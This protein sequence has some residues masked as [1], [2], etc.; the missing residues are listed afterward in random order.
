[1]RQ[2]RV[3]AGAVT[4]AVTEWP[5]AGPPLVL[6]HGIGSRAASWLPVAP[7]LRPICGMLKATAP[8]RYI[9]RILPSIVYQRC[10]PSCAP[11]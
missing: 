11:G 1:M 3:A 9:E 8:V 5:T 4:L 6:L 10:T 7:M 2:R